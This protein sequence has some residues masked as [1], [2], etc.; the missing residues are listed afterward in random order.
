MNPIVII[1]ARMAATRL[2]GKPLADIGGLPMIVRVLKAAELAGVGDVVVAAG[3]PEI[4]W[5]IEAAGGRAI[6]TDPS[7]PSGSDR[8]L[9]ALAELDPQGDHDV[10]INLQ[11]DMPFVDPEILGACI[12][13]LAAEPGCDIATVV[14]P[15]DS[16]DDRTNPDV[17]KPVLALP[18]GARRGRA[19]YFTRSTLYGAGPVFR[20]EEEA[21]AC[22]AGRLDDDRPGQRVNLPSE[23]RFCELKAIVQRSRVPFAPPHTVWR[24]SVGYWRIGAAPAL[25]TGAPQARKARRSKAGPAPDT[26]ALD[27]IARQPLLPIKPQQPLDIGLF[28]RRLPE[29]PHIVVPDE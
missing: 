12:D 8:I 23:D 14:A 5:A 21:R 6:L 16:E 11:G 2:P 1:P 4:A 29:S 26:D 9:A 24:L 13:L 20:H 17:V 22:Y 18:S 3:D 7:L 19:L 28:E 15:E 27:A 10:V 25:A